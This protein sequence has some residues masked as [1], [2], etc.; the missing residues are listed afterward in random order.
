MMIEILVILTKQ[1]IDVST[2]LVN[3]QNHLDDFQSCVFGIAISMMLDYSLISFSQHQLTIPFQIDV[4][5]SGVMFMSVVSC[6]TLNAFRAN[7][8]IE[9]SARALFA[10]QVRC[11]SSR[12][13]FLSNLNSCELQV[14]NLSFI[15][16]NF[17]GL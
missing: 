13:M 10:A 6:W 17:C 12:Q 1:Q 16:T 8:Y 11:S 14:F 7:P 4:V 15:L 3:C 9:Y 5:S 2:K